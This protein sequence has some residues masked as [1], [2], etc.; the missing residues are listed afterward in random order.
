MQ[1]GKGFISLLIGGAIG[2]SIVLLFA[3]KKGEKVREDIKT[4]FDDAVN[5]TKRKSR[6]LFRQSIDMVEDI[7]Q[8]ADE[9][10][11]L[12]R[13]YSEGTYEETVDKIEFEIRRLRKV[14]FAAIDTY[15]E[16]RSEDKTSNEI[17]NKIYNEFENDTV[18]PK[19]H[20]I[21]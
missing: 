10:R 11:D 16:S 21:N 1:T 5:K 18:P 7:V 9:L 15:K 2:S 19:K 20:L 4:N 14:L 17:V 13:K 6:R 3:P 8:K 12:V